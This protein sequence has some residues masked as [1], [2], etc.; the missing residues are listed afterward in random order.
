MGYSGFTF[1]TTEVSWAEFVEIHSNFR[2]SKTTE[3]LRYAATPHSRVFT[4]RGGGGGGRL[5]TLYK[6]I[7]HS[8][9]FFTA[10]TCHNRR[11]I[12]SM[13]TAWEVRL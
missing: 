9:P 10:K 11:E 3:N 1:L 13:S 5:I 6:Q 4:G 12:E 2:L 7:K 8:L